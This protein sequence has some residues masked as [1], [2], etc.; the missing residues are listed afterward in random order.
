M[1]PKLRRCAF[2]QPDRLDRLIRNVD[3]C[4][5]MDTHHVVMWLHI[6]FQPRRPVMETHLGQQSVLGEGSNVLVN[7]SQRDGWDLPADSLIHSLGTGMAIQTGEN[8]P[9]HLPLVR[10]RETLLRTQ[11]T[12]LAISHNKNYYWIIFILCQVAER[13]SSYIRRRAR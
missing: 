7:G 13:F 2:L 5:A 6:C 9:D 12:E 10:D 1:N 8:V 11:I 4:L 3:D